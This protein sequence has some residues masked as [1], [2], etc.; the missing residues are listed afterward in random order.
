MMWKM[1]SGGRLVK[2]LMGT[3]RT[4]SSLG[5][6]GA[7]HSASS[8]VAR[9]PS[10]WCCSLWE[11]LL[12]LWLRERGREG[13]EPHDRV[14]PG[15]LGLSIGS[16]AMR[17]IMS[18]LSIMAVAVEEGRQW[19]EASSASVGRQSATEGGPGGAL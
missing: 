12:L 9:L 4:A 1:S 7:V 3:T 16:K 11:R 8:A 17:S 19:K 6:D 15:G 10:L 5:F 13:E 2:G 14:S 18:A